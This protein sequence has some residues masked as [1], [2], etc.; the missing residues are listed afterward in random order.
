MR[1]NNQVH[2]ERNKPKPEDRAKDI[3][4]KLLE[5]LHREFFTH[6]SDED[7]DQC[8]IKES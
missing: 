3:N 4:D 8:Q 6:P 1:K 5:K 2:I 7:A